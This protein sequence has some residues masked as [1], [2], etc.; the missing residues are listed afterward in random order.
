L[1][2]VF[3]AEKPDAVSQVFIAL[4]F[5]AG[6]MFGIAVSFLLLAAVGRPMDVDFVGDDVPQHSTVVRVV[7]VS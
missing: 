2:A 4:A 1:L 3:A 7:A 6:V 5:V